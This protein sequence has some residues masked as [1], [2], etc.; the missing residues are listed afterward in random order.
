M[1]YVLETWVNALVMWSVV[2]QEKRVVGKGQTRKSPRQ[3]GGNE[4]HE[5]LDSKK[6][7]R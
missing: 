6:L 1:F 7:T 5:L 2:F 4:L 3:S